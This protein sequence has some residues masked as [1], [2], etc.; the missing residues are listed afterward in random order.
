MT[1]VISSDESSTPSTCRWSYLAVDSSLL[2]LSSPDS[3]ELSSSI[4]LIV[5]RDAAFSRSLALI[6][7]TC[8]PSFN[9]LAWLSLLPS[10]VWSYNT[11]IYCFGQNN[12]SHSTS[13]LRFIGALSMAL[14]RSRS[15]ANSKQRTLVR[16][17]W[18]KEIILVH[19]SGIRGLPLLLCSWTLS[20]VPC[21]SSSWLPC[22]R[23]SFSSLS[24]SRIS[25][26][27]FERSFVGIFIC[28]IN[29]NSEF[30]CGYLRLVQPL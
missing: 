11:L 20:P 19:L 13:P 8:L 16:S 30:D 4:S 5:G 15:V 14:S 27:Y 1:S 10:R 17:S 22:H 3:N 26:M 7:V 18:L 28:L 24:S 2:E 29:S 6:D 23:S 9:S 25:L 21:F 12:G